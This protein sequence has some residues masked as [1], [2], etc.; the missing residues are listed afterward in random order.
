[1]LGTSIKM[2]LEEYGLLSMKK[3]LLYCWLLKRA[4][5]ILQLNYRK[6]C[7]EWPTRGPFQLKISF[8]SSKD[9]ALISWHSWLQSNGHQKE[10]LFTKF[11]RMIQICHSEL[12]LCGAVIQ[13]ALI[14][15]SELVPTYWYHKNVSLDVLWWQLCFLEIL[16]V[17][18]C[19]KQCFVR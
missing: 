10:R 1:L 18:K 3:N 2:V 11:L 16:A 14:R 5:S 15:H 4:K 19:L 12:S 13:L 7:L 17:S 9:A 8:R 6:K